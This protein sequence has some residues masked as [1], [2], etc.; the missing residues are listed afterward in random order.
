MIDSVELREDLSTGSLLIYQDISFHD[1][2]GDVYYI[3]FVLVSDLPNIQTQD[4]AI[5]TSSEEQKSGAILTGTWTCGDGDYQVTLQAT[6]L[7]RAGNRSNTIE[8]TM[9]C[10]N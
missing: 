2:E 6:I 9:F 1:A 10:H 4:G 5:R 8:Y 3:D 7:D